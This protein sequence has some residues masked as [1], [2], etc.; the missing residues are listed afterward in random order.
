MYSSICVAENTQVCSEL[1]SS[2]TSLKNAWFYSTLKKCSCFLWHVCVN[3][4]KMYCTGGRWRD[5]WSDGSRRTR[6]RPRG[7]SP[8]H[9]ALLS[10]TGSPPGYICIYQTNGASVFSFMSSLPLL[11]PTPN[12]WKYW[13][14]E[15][16]PNFVNYYPSY[17]NKFCEFFLHLY[18]TCTVC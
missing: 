1:T 14:A 2:D 12:C 17:S 7:S 11:P 6:S 16:I 13:Y 3:I 4:N 9:S 15:N 10:H 8:G 18:C 5:L